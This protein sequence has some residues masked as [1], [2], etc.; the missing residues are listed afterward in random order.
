MARHLIK[1]SK[2]ILDKFIQ[3][4]LVENQPE[5][6]GTQDKF[7]NGRF[8]LGIDDLPFHVYEQIEEIN[9]S[10]ILYQN[11]ERYISDESSKIAMS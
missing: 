10:E 11:I 9:D 7:T 3:S 1:K 2:N 6:F 8:M 5:L 4:Q